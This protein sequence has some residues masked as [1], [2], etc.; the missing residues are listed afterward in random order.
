MLGD[1]GR[2]GR[3]AVVA[4]VARDMRRGAGLAAE[5]QKMAAGL[6][7]W[8]VGVEQRGERRSGGLV[9]AVGRDSRA[10]VVM[11]ASMLER[12]HVSVRLRGMAQKLMVES[13]CGS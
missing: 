7:W 8:S 12:R 10:Q 6:A 1:D 9:A 13:I 3:E 2:I 5:N 4:G 11:A